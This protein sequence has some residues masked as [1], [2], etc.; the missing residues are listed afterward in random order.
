VELIKSAYFCTIIKITGDIQEIP[1]MTRAIYME[2]L[3]VIEDDKPS[4]FEN[5]PKSKIG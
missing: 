3:K 4:K 5:N 2:K 1:G